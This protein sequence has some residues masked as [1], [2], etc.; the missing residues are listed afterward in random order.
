M[1]SVGYDLGTQVLEIEFRD[2][3]VYQYF[4]VHASVHGSLMEA[5]SK[6]GY[7][8]DHIRDRYRYRQVE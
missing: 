6:G 4:A 1:V 2:G 7:F 3:S 5:P 8:H